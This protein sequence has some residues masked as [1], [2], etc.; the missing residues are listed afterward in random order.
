MMRITLLST[1]SLLAANAV[2]AGAQSQTHTPPGCR[3][4]PGDIEWPSALA[5]KAL[6]LT[7]GGKLIAGVPLGRPCFN[8]GASQAR[9]TALKEHFTELEPFTEDPVNVMSPYWQNNSCS[10]FLGPTGTCSLGNLASYAI[11]VTSAADVIAGIVFATAKNIRLTIKNTG[12]DFLGRSA[13]AGSLAL[14]THHLQEITFFRFSSTG[15]SGPAVR[16]GAGVDGT[17][18]LPAAKAAGYRVVGGSCPTVGVTGGFTQG[19][20]HSPLS[21]KYG[22]G[23]DQ[24]LEYDVVTAL[25]IRTTASPTKNPALFWALR[26]GG[27]GN[28]AVVL[29]MTVKV[30]PDG[31]SAG[32]GFLILNDGDDTK[33]W[34]AMSAWFKH[35]LVLDKI[36]GYMTG[37]TMGRDFLSLAFA[38]LPD[39]TSVTDITAPL[40]PFFDELA[41]LN[42]T[43]AQ[44]SAFISPSYADWYTSWAVPVAYGTNNALGGRL[45]P[46]TVVQNNLPALI[47]VFRDI[48][49]VSTPEI[50]F[51]VI[52]GITVNLTTKRI[53]NAANPGTSAVLPAWREALFT[54][55]FGIPFAANAPVSTLKF[56]QAW[57]NEKQSKLRAVTPG[58]GTYMNEATFDN[59]NW[60]QDYFGSNYNAL[61]A[62]KKTYDPLGLLWAHSAVG[63]DVSWK[64]RVDGRLCKV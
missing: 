18:L 8:P 40:Q 34:K 30:Y 1:L 54:L 51:S 5:W 12:H 17:D 63:S 27:A 58:G 50:E 14:W 36:P 19:G 3:A 35:L 26:G 23:A 32:A 41:T 52:N 56:G 13:G 11:K 57:I 44:N 25:G 7:V 24:V 59:P 22:L 28:Y 48:V 39:T 31:P 15:Y 20:G 29:S 21:A 4:F 61:L 49:E 2:G 10:P 46:R 47:N 6:N 60:K 55:N 16:L 33:Y 38:L 9:C 45:V 43:L 62:V 53:G 37:F 42:V 64:Q